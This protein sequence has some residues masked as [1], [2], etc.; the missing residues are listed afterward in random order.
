MNEVNDSGTI[1]SP[2]DLQL[3]QRSNFAVQHLMAAARFA[4][5]CKQVEVNHAGEPFGS[6]YDEIIAN[7]TAVVLLSVAC[8]EAYI[9]EL[10]AD[11]APKFDEVAVNL[12]QE[13]WG[14]IEEKSILEKYQMAL[15][16]KDKPKFI[17][18]EEPYQ[19]V[20]ILIKV[21]NILVHFKPEWHHKQKQ[22]AK[23]G[24]MLQGKFSLSPFVEGDAP[25]FPTKSMTFGMAKWAV[26]SSINF[27]SQFSVKA[28]LPNRL[29]RFMDKLK[30]E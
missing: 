10:Y 16:M 29:E 5:Q 9:N 24:R 19:S 17:Q 28:D 11:G 21:R 30:L 20:D 7:T 6:F 8:L 27:I 23:I 2:S 22:H 4:R 25:I 14:L 18:G 1:N 15:V 26:E 13:I 3:T 12:R